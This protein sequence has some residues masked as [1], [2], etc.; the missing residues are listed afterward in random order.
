VTFIGMV[1]VADV[2]VVVGCENRNGGLM[3][4]PDFIWW[5][6]SPNPGSEHKGERMNLKGLVLVQQ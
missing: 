6:A 5:D 2:V 3:W 4:L 1:V